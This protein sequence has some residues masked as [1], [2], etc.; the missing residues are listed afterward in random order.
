MRIVRHLL[1]SALLLCTAAPGQ[2]AAITSRAAAQGP[3]VRLG[4]LLGPALG[5]LP[6]LAPPALSAA[7]LIPAPAALQPALAE[8]LI[9]RAEVPAAEASAVAPPAESARQTLET[10]NSVL[11]D[12]SPQDLKDMPVEKLQALAS[13]VM[14]RLDGRL[15]GADSL[16]GVAVLSQARAR[17]IMERRG[18]TTENLYNPGHPE[19]HADLIDV[20]GTPER[21]RPVSDRRVYRHYTTVE[22]QAAILASG[23]LWNGYLPYVE[24][25]PGVF[26][27]TFADI[28]GVFLT[29]PKVAGDSVGVP[30]KDFKAWVDIEVPEALPVLEVERG[31]IFLIPLPGRTRDWVVKLY[32]D[33][34]SGKALP[35]HEQDT[36]FKVAAEGPGPELR[37]PVRVVGHGL[38]R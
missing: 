11:K 17:K 27:K 33:W 26:R 4:A 29:L 14:D 22:G 31:T 38:L 1:L 19:N 8:A 9:L 20:R 10:V 16:P 18:K 28:T 3:L 6:E 24:L 15:S 37:V 13:V 12:F 21:V 30:S 5:R 32:R 34:L 36:A 25:A 7:S 2:T 35:A 23:S